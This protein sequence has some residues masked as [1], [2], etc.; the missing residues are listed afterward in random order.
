M[1][2]NHSP[3]GLGRGRGCVR[4]RKAM[5]SL[6]EFAAEKLGVLGTGEAC[7]ACPEVTGAG[8]DF[9]L[10]GDGRRLLSFSCNDLSQSQ[11]AS[12]DHRRRDRRDGALRHWRRRLAASL[13]GNH[14]L[15]AELR[16]D[17]WRG[18]KAPKR[19]AS[20]GSGFYLANTWHRSGAGRAR[21]PD[22]PRRVIARLCLC[23]RQTQ[24]RKNSPL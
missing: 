17:G 3:P 19:L 22:R 11:P 10:S 7:G 4:V 23:W 6:S 20:S 5:R 21:R 1:T 9:G 2:V 13:T 12:E 24:R 16:R 14:L 15:Y 8:R 18:S